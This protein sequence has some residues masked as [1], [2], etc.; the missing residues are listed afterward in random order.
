[1]SIKNILCA[2]SGESAKSSGLHHAIRLAQ[3][4]GAWLTGVIPHGR[5]FLESRFAGQV[6][7]DIL[8]TLQE[9]D[10]Q[11]I[12]GIRAR[13]AEEVAAAGLS[14]RSEFVELDTRSGDSVEAFA[15]GFDQVV[16]GVHTDVASAGH[17]SAHP[18]QIALT[19]GRPVL[20]VPDGYESEGLADHAIVAWDGKRSAARALGDAMPI[21]EEKAS[22]TI[23]TVG[24][25]P[26]HGVERIVQNLHRHGISAQHLNKPRHKT[27]ANTLLE[28]ADEIGAKLI[29]MGAFE[30]SKFHHDLL[31]GVTTDV[32]RDAKVPVFMSH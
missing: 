26:V 20:V 25:S 3:H 31:G 15:R 32:M 1:M 5:P 30:H 10:D 2:Y 23:L 8:R 12:A 18:D 21:L 29:V 11:H 17:L 27:V 9:A 24:S 14:D 22:V 6:T 13:F 16:A 28:T 4:H 19:S 7:D